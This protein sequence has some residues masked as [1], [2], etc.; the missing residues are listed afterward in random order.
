MQAGSASSGVRMPTEQGI[1]SR[2]CG[3]RRGP[4]G[5]HLHQWGAGYVRVAVGR[6]LRAVGARSYPSAL[7]RPILA[8]HVAYRWI[9]GRL[10]IY[11]NTAAFWK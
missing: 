6:G 10:I 5:E 9:V 3:S 4:V 11:R 2:C 8:R 7:R 1:A